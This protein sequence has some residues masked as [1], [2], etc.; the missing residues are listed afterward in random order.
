MDIEGF[1]LDALEGAREL[2]T[3]HQ[4][5]LLIAVYHRFEHLW[6]VPLWIHQV[7]PTYKLH[8]RHHSPNL[9][10]TVCY[11]VPPENREIRA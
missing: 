11:A 6:K 10:E 8:L 3:T 1:E 2:I 7:N 9:G 4:P 5:A